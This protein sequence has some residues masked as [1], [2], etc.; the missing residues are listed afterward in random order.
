MKLD[1]VFS[2]FFY[3]E[4][5]LE[6][7]RPSSKRHSKLHSKLEVPLALQNPKKELLCQ[8]QF[9]PKGRYKKLT[10]G[11]FFG[12]VYKKVIKSFRRLSLMMIPVRLFVLKKALKRLLP[13]NQSPKP[14]QHGGLILILVGK[15]NLSRQRQ[16]FQKQDFWPEPLKELSLPNPRT[17]KSRVVAIRCKK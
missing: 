14:V 7:K 5:K 12:R 13:K 4:N 6:E 2:G 9:E 3:W 10:R 15:E 16:H 8:G 1:S 11:L 17:K